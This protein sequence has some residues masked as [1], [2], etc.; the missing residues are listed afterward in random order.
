MMPCGRSRDGASPRA[1]KPI[2]IR[3]FGPATRSSAFGTDRMPVTVMVQLPS[4]NVAVEYAMAMSRA[5]HLLL[6]R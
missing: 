2:S 6:P 3:C 4:A 1:V 5:K